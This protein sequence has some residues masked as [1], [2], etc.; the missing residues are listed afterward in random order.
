MPRAKRKRSISNYA[1]GDSESEGDSDADDA[2]SEEKSTQSKPRDRSLSHASATPP[3]K[4]HTSNAGSS[5]QRP[6]RE[7]KTYQKEDFVHFDAA[8]GSDD[9][10]DEEEGGEEEMALE[11]RAE[12]K[13]ELKRQRDE[14]KKARAEQKAELKRQRDEAKEAKKEAKEVK[15][16]ASEQ[17]RQELE[18]KKAKKQQE[19][20]EITARAP[21]LLTSLIDQQQDLEAKLEEA[22]A[23]LAQKAAA[24]Q[25][26]KEEHEMAQKAV[27]KIEK[28][29]KTIGDEFKKT[30]ALIFKPLAPP[31][32]RLDPTEKV[33]QLWKGLAK[34][35]EDEKALKTFMEKRQA[36]T[37]KES[38]GRLEKHPD[39]RYKRLE[40]LQATRNLCAEVLQAFADKET[41]YFADPLE[42]FKHKGG[43]NGEA[44]K[45][46]VGENGVST[47]MFHGCPGSAAENID[48]TGFRMDFFHRGMLGTN[49]SA[50]KGLYGAPDP[51]KSMVYALKGDPLDQKTPDERIMYVC[52]F[53]LSGEGGKE[54]RHA[55]PGT[56]NNN[57][58]FH[59][60]CVFDNT[61][62]V[63]I[64]KLKVKYMP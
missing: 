48:L 45:H 43:K 41:K 52:R 19:E 5:S 20:K 32:S 57:H 25:K 2:L 7:R 13:A 33:M 47:L 10:D 61:H 15:E 60:M 28:E 24:L 55:G 11:E 17:K 26:A 50:G 6:S 56:G 12:Q 39:G 14:A 51:R 63:P 54:A 37:E 16:K 58:I 62:V 44:F 23:D 53:Y 59:E 42:A 22:Q 4:L 27:K 49:A 34:G 18:A 21:Q 8:K 38:G 40:I 46:K 30:S 29:A 64:W 31:V 1:E 9:D 36:D 3:A 35:I